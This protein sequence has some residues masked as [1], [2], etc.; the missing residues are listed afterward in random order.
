MSKDSLEGRFPGK[1]S[2][3]SGNVAAC[4]VRFLSLAAT[5]SF[6]IM[7][8]L[9]GVLGGA[10]SDLLCSAPHDASPLTGMVPMYLLMS[11]FHSTPWLKLISSTRSD[12]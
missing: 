10:H 9:T 8:L 11:V 2:F 6:G 3:E 5:P 4:A 1:L 7:A 12:A